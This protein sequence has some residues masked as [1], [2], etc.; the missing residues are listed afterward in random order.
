MFYLYVFLFSNKTNH[1]RKQDPSR[2]HAQ[3]TRPRSVAKQK[4]IQAI[5]AAAATKK[6]GGGRRSEGGRSDGRFGY[7]GHDEGEDGAGTG[8]GRVMC[9]EKHAFQIQR[10][11]VNMIEEQVKVTSN[12]VRYVC[13]SL[14][15]CNQ[16]STILITRYVLL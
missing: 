8:D 10:S 14:S 6:R 7:V 5:D 3:P 12:K 11:A 13:L 16:P 4:I 15:F 1:Q 9:C 2:P